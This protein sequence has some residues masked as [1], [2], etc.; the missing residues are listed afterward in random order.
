MAGAN[1]TED[2]E[3]AAARLEAALERIARAARPATG[4]D[5]QTAVSGEVRQRLD[6]VIQQI[7]RALETQ[8]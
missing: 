2:A 6:R 1:T 3:V 5:G 8:S 4:S 7:R